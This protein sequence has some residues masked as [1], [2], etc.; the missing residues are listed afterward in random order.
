MTLSQ[1][2]GGGPATS[3]RRISISGWAVI[4]ASTAL[5][6]PSRSTA[7]ALPAGT[8]CASAVAMIS[9]PS[10]RISSCSRPMA[11]PSASS[12]RNELEQTSSASRDVECAGVIRSGRISC[13]T[14]AH[15][16]ASQLPGRL[17]SGEA[18]ADHVDRQVAGGTHASAT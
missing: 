11:L 8:R 15:A 10:R 1:S 9:E 13:R 17:A 5:L 12:E 7:S 14:A 2:A 3:S 16:G 4:A 6:K 18:A